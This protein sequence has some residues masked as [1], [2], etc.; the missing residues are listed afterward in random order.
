M[1]DRPNVPETSA[2]QSGSG[3]ARGP[4]RLK[5]PQSLAR[6]RDRV[7]EAADQLTRLRE[8]NEALRARIEQL[9]QRP[10]V[11]PDLTLLTFEDDPDAL[12]RKIAGFI[13]TLDD[14]LGDH[15]QD[16]A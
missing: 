12:R 14:Y 5:S 9:E 4:A 13:A 1:S 6:L 10:V 2:A 3:A 8:E 11:D 7:Q 15:T 16:D